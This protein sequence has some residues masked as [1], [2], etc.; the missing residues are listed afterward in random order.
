MPSA[1]GGVKLS[2]ALIHF[3]GSGG[4]SPFGRPRH[5]L[6]PSASSSRPSASLR[7]PTQVAGSPPSSGVGAVG[8]QQHDRADE[9]PAR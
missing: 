7:M 6:T 2:I 5:C 8:R 9:P 1:F 3:G 4:C